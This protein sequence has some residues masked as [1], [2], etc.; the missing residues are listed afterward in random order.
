MAGVV[1]RTNVGYGSTEIHDSHI[2]LISIHYGSAASDASNSNR[3]GLQL[4]K[5][6]NNG[7]SLVPEINDLSF[8]KPVHPH[9]TLY[10]PR[11]RRPSFPRS[12]A[13]SPTFPGGYS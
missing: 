9:Q 7:P 1:C 4:Q 13:N 6:A 3:V 8:A 12:G 10:L 2:L 11:L 5:D